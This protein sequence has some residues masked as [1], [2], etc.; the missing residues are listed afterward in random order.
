MRARRTLRQEASA[1]H[2]EQDQPRGT[3]F[4][5]VMR[6]ALLPYAASRLVLVAVGLVANFYLLPMTVNSGLRA[7]F[8]QVFWLM[9]QRFDSDFYLNIA[10]SGYGQ[11]AF[12]EAGG[13]D[14]VFL[15]LYP[16]LMAGL[17]SILG[18][19][20]T[21]FVLAGVLIS[22][23]AGLA[24]ATYLYLLVRDE[25][26]REVA[27]RVVL[28]LAFFPM[29]FY[30]SAVYTEALFLALAVAC[31]YHAR[32]QSWWIAALCG[33]LAAASR[34]QGIVLIVPLAWEYSRVLSARYAPPPAQLDGPW[35]VRASIRVRCYVRGLILASRELRNW[36]TAAS[37]A[38]VPA[39]LVSF[40]LYGFAQTGDLLIFFR[41]S[42]ETWG[43]ALS[44]PWHAL[45]D[46]VRH[47]MLGD[48]MN[49]SFWLLNLPLA[50][51]FL[52]C[53]ILSF[54]YLPAVYAIY[55]AVMVVLP[56]SATVL[57]SL[58]RLYLV[59]F[60]AFVLLALWSRASD[61]RRH[62]LILA[63]LATS[64][65]LFMAFFVVGMPAIV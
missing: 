14:W 58:G 40:M 5:E 56:L 29:S 17:G 15:P 39:G 11:P 32:R 45:S 22:N 50:I 54:R 20:G 18:G 37:L 49:Y 24:A 30:L 16:L 6:D 31:L 4:S 27:Q 57:M 25:W 12:G 26:S 19:S 47:P 62:A 48:P 35:R 8:P 59:V 38:L 44:F 13:V 43:R 1:T 2:V 46:A 41:V 53:V 28:Y 65:A 21:A 42:D 9:W 10:Q 55:T 23:T 7:P 52:A 33:G 3:T 63:S 64:Q 60:P 51:I 61:S 34:P 36:F